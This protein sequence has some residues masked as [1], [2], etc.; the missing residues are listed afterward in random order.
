MAVC[1]ELVETSPRPLVPVMTKCRMTMRYF[2]PNLNLSSDHFADADEVTIEQP[3]TGCGTVTVF[4]DIVKRDSEYCA[5]IKS[6]Y[7]TYTL[8][9]IFKNTHFDFW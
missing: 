1:Q 8:C 3:P 6:H 5:V 9:L 7:H 4:N 2:G